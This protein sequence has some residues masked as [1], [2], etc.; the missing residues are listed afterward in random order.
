MRTLD[1]AGDIR[2]KTVFVRADFDVPLLRQGF[3]GQA[4]AIAETFRIERQ[5]PTLEYLLSR[6]ARVVLAAHISAVPSFEPLKPQLQ[7]LLGVTFGTDV[8]L[9]ENT[10]QNP[11]EEANDES[12]AREL[13]AGCD[14]YVNNAFAVCHRAHASV[15]AAARLL[16]AYAGLLVQEETQRL[17]KFI[18]APAQGKV[19]YIGGAKASTKIPVIEHLIERAEHMVVGGIAANEILD[20]KT[21]VDTHNPKLHLPTDF[22]MDDG[23]ARDIGPETAR[24][25]SALAMGASLI[26]WNGPMG[27]FEDARFMAG[28]EAIAR[29]IAASG[30]L[31]IVGGGDTISAVDVLGLLEKFT[32]VSTGGGAMLVFLAGTQ[33]PGLKVLGYYDEA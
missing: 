1:Q 11:G 32:F 8:V 3:G 2:G 21:D 12:F 9:L 6:G 15:V 7:Q 10:R 23:V 30:A 27:R 22:V 25:F 20:G 13:I 29:A 28:T 14:I 17:A 24:V 33:L 18:D 26:V 5:K 19:V 16:P 31:S 4:G